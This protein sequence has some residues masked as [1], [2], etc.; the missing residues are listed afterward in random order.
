MEFLKCIQKEE[1][2]ES[3]NPDG[4]SVPA[5]YD[6]PTLTQE[7]PV[8]EE[9]VK[10][11]M[12]YQEKQKNLHKKYLWVLL[13]RV[14]ELYEKTGQSLEDITIPRYEMLFDDDK[15]LERSRETS[16]FGLGPIQ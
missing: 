2:Y 14:M 16:R 5:S 13:N 1:A 8:T 9:W 3:I 4:L 6:G 10:S 12:S 7:E 11:L 15:S